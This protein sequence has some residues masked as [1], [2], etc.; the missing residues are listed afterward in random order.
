V[1]S[2]LKIRVLICNND[3]KETS[4]IKS[5]LDKDMR[6]PWSLSHCVSVKEA[7]SR[8]SATD[9]I[10]LKP[11]MEGLLTPKEVFE[12]I[13]DVAIEVP[14][15][16]LTNG[17]D[18]NG[19]STYVM[20]KGA[21]DTIIRGQFARIVDAIEF[22]LIRQKIKDDTRKSEAKSRTDNDNSNLAEHEK[23]KQILRFFAGG[24]SIDRQ[25]K[26]KN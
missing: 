15:L 5:W 25:D 20:E 1:T 11:E 8:I 23:Y 6:V 2:D 22:A 10:I 19:L 24:Y 13:E 26:S 21:A 7:R 18:E 4:I 3:F 16:V 14:I 9:I 12:D 17:P